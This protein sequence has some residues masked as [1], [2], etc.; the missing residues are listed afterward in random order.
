MVAKVASPVMIFLVLA[1]FSHL[2]F[3]AI[4]LVVTPSTKVT[5]YFEGDI[6]YRKGTNAP[7]INPLS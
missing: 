7:N 1:T 2:T 4:T 3:C 5:P 6:S